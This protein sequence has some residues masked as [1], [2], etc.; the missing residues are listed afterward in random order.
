MTRPSKLPT[1]EK[2]EGEVTDDLRCERCG[3][4]YTI[5]WIAE[6]QS[7]RRNHLRSAPRTNPIV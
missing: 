3:R 5:H 2:C 1:C 7:G 4:E 6:T